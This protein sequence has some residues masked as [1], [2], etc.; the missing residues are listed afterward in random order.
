ME[1]YADEIRRLGYIVEIKVNKIENENK[2]V[3][4]KR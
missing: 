2:I 3:Q 4:V 1:R